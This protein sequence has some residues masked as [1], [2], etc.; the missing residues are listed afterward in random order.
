MQCEH[1]DF[2]VFTAI[3]R[4]FAAAVLLAQWE[5]Y[6][7]PLAFRLVRRKGTPTFR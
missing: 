7:I 5:V 4:E 6:R 1:A 2:V 3:A